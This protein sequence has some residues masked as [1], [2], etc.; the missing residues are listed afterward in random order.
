MPKR[1]LKNAAEE[2]MAAAENTQMADQHFVT[3]VTKCDGLLHELDQVKGLLAA[4]VKDHDE[5][6]SKT[7]VWEA[8]SNEAGFPTTRYCK[9]VSQ[10][11]HNVKFPWKM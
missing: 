3:G 5:E 8:F 9:L 11:V 7:A 6:D 1:S 2:A 4:Y 10:C